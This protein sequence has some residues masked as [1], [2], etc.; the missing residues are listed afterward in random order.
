MTPTNSTCN[1]GAGHDEQDAEI[2]ESECDSG[3]DLPQK[4]KWTHTVLAYEVAKRWVTGERA[5]KDEAEVQKTIP[6]QKTIPDHKSL[7]TNLGLWKHTR[8]LTDK[9]NVKFEVY[10][11]PM[12][13]QQVQM[14]CPSCDIF[15]LY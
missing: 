12:R 11:C 8:M 14:L 5:E 9:R 4:Q 2:S 10:R 7:S 3:E 15:R 6:G 1:D 13:Y